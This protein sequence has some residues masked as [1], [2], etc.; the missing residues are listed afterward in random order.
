MTTYAV[1]SSGGAVFE[2][3]V[4][5]AAGGASASGEAFVRSAR[6]PLG[7][8]VPAVVGIATS[9]GD[10]PGTVEV[11]DSGVVLASVTGLGPGPGATVRVNIGGRCERVPTPLGGDIIVGFCN[12]AGDV[13]LQPYSELRTGAPRVVNVL[14]FGARADADG[15]GGGT[16]ASRAFRRAIRALDPFRGGIV[17]VPFGNYRLAR[18]VEIDRPVIIRGHGAE[19]HYPATVI[20][21]DAGVTGFRVHSEVKL[22]DLPPA[23]VTSGNG[24]RGTVIEHLAIRAAAQATFSVSGFYATGRDRVLLDAPGD[25][26]NG[27][28]IRIQGG[29]PA[30]IELPGILADIAPGSAA[31]EVMLSGVPSDHM[32]PADAGQY[33]LIGRRGDPMAPYPLPTRVDAVDRSGADVILTM[34]SPPANVGSSQPLR[35]VA[36]HFAVIRDGGGTIELLIDIDGP[37]AGLLSEVNGISTTISH[38]DSGI[39]LRT[40]ATVRHCTIGGGDGGNNGFKQGAGV[41]IGASTTCTPDPG[42]PSVCPPAQRIGLDGNANG[43]R[44]EHVICAYNRHGLVLYGKDVNAGCA[45]QLACVGDAGGGTSWLIVDHSLLGNTYL[46]SHVTGGLGMVTGPN[47]G[48]RSTVIGGYVEGGTWC[49]LGLGTNVFGGTRPNDVGGYSWVGQYVNRMTIGQNNVGDGGAFSSYRRIFDPNLYF[50]RYRHASS[51]SDYDFRKSESG[52]GETGWYLHT[53]PGVPYTVPFA[54]SDSDASVGVGHFWMPRGFYFGG[55]ITGAPTWLSDSIRVDVADVAPVDA[56]GTIL[57]TR[58]DVIFYKEPDAGGK[59]GLRCVASQNGST[60]AVWRPWG[61]IDP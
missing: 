8:A 3:D 61:T 15:M 11:V 51:V 40:A 46:A 24:A 30:S 36:D 33:V 5:Y 52:D 4:V 34:A 49:F 26:R 17:E 1:S 21:C 58:G 50:E 60:N 54:W 23:L 32:S 38:G 59:M 47:A 39:H 42:D 44:I 43:W 13:T 56:S 6:A 7:G 31:N 14:H 19:Y 28:T 18:E 45:D 41:L 22:S 55:A 2:S 16:D 37:V 12:S 25:F 20:Y 29:G 57:G 35:L 27:Q 53:Y 10:Y 9:Y 48:Q